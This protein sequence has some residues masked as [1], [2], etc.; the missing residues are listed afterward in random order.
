VPINIDNA[1]TTELANI[2]GCR[3]ESLPFAYLGLPLG[4]TR[5]SVSDLMPMVS[6]IDKKLSGISS[7]MSYTGKLTLLNSVIQSLP[8]YAMYSFKVPVTIFV[9][10]EKSE[11]QFLWFDRE[12]KIQEKCLASWEMMCRPK[13]Q[14]GLGILNLRVQN[15]AVLMKN[16]HKFYNNAYIPWVKLIWKA[17]YENRGTPQT[18]NT[19]ASFWWRDCLTFQEKYKEITNVDIQN[20]KSVI[21]WKDSWNSDIRQDL[22]PHL[23]SFAK[24]QKITIQKAVE[25][26]NENIYDMFH[27]PLSTVAHE[28]MHNLEQELLDLSIT[29]DDHI[30]SFNWGSN[31]STRKVYMELI[32]NHPTPN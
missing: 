12:N 9:H 22:Y 23:H 30:W 4:T 32:G 3:V 2:F 11:R 7:L 14:G 26:N 15:Q 18:I 6:R 16:L 19:K 31:F 13:D 10:F 25:A 28:E 29:A 21:L 17:Y 8:M 5:P 20:E 24:N 1:K 27:P